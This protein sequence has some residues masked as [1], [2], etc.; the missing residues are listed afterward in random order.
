MSSS[1]SYDQKLVRAMASLLLKVPMLTVP[2][3]MRAAKFS[4]AQSSHPAL[5]MRVRCAL[6]T[7]KGKR[8]SSLIGG[9]VDISSPMESMS[10]FSTSP[11][12]AASTSAASTAS[13]ATSTTLTD[14]IARPLNNNI[15]L[16]AV[17][18][19]KNNNNKKS[20]HQHMSQSTKRATQLYYDELQKPAGERQSADSI[21]WIHCFV[22]TIL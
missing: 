19:S 21:I 6:S 17:G 11:P 3:A 2:Q 22:D 1:D 9:S 16:T 18:K 8:K 5:Q 13:S 12:S 4:S 7:M 20:L 15:H 14:F 10:E